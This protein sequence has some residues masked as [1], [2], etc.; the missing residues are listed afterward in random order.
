VLTSGLN[1]GQTT[2]QTINP[3][4]AE[5]ASLET[6]GAL[7]RTW[8][9][10]VKE[11]SEFSIASKDSQDSRESNSTAH[12]SSP[13]QTKSFVES[14]VSP[15]ERTWDI[16]QGIDSLTSGRAG[17]R[18]EEKKEEPIQ[19]VASQA[20]IPTTPSPAQIAQVPNPVAQQPTIPDTRPV[21]NIQGVPIPPQNLPR[22]P[23][24]TQPPSQEPISPPPPTPLPPPEQLL[25]SPS[26]I[27]PNPQAIPGKVPENIVVDRFEFE[28]NTAISSEELAAVTAPFT[29]KPISFAELFQARAA[30]TDLYLKRGYITSGA[31]IPPQQLQGGVVKIQVIEGGLEAINVRGT[32][33]LN[34][35]YVRSRLRIAT[36]KPLNRD[37]LLEALQLLQLNPLIQNISAELAAGTEPGANLLDV[38]VTEAKTFN[39]QIGLDNNRAPSVGTFRRRVQINQANLFGLGDGLNLGYSN[40]DGSN[41]IDLGYTL[42]I[43]PRN[44]T[45]RFSYGITK[46]N[47]VEPPFDRI[48]IRS[49]SNYYELSLRQPL[50]QTPSQ[51]LALGLTATRQETDTSVLEIPFPLSAGADDRGR[52]RISALRFF[53]E[54]TKR[55]SR[56]VIA[57]RSQFS[58]GLDVLNA[59]INKEAPDSRFFSW[60]GQAQWVRLLAPETLL[61]L[62]ADVQLADRALVPLEQFGLGGQE[63]VRGYRQDILLQDNGA[64]ASAEVRIPI[65]R[66]PQWNALLQVAPFLDF[67]SAWTSSGN[68]NP[69]P[70]ILVST[71]VGLQLQLGD[72]LSVR[73]DYGIPLVSVSSRKRSWQE[74]GFYF[75]IVAT[76]FTF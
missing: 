69:D 7:I 11:N 47:V 46:S 21:P 66:I 12:S 19:Q 62:R 71:G 68:Q 39:V 15:L 52:T 2:A 55:T 34:P 18:F 4:K 17:T 10:E 23:D 14:V 42:P 3:E 36:D 49:N 31:L 28:G 63:S 43:N 13:F 22:Q 24:R 8:R 38:Q 65:V 53:Q 59:T 72:R 57:A 9:L 61:L 56:E 44:G 70:N 29:K 30:V 33:R 64:L 75:S 48:D 40:T 20:N 54:W 58:V 67:G 16:S 45:L 25:E 1:A 6:A 60:R 51:E 37:R 26:S 5:D 50:L 41:S 27:P 73:L 35:E 32:Q 76:P 74:N